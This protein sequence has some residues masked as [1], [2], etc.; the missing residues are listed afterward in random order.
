MTTVNRFFNELVS[1]RSGRLLFR[2]FIK[3]DCLDRVS[4]IIGLPSS[5]ISQQFDLIV[6]RL[7]EEPTAASSLIIVPYYSTNVDSS[8]LLSIVLLEK[9]DLLQNF[10]MIA[11]WDELISKGAESIL[12][13]D[14]NSAEQLLSL[15]EQLCLSSISWSKDSFD[16]LINSPFY[17]PYGL[18]PYFVFEEI[19]S[20][21]LCI[22]T[23]DIEID[24]TPF[25]ASNPLWDEELHMK[26]IL[27]S[28]LDFYRS[29]K[30][31]YQI[32]TLNVEKD[33][34]DYLD[35]PEAKDLLI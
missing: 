29:A 35:S 1:K 19:I 2:E 18:N 17:V 24:E 20:T 25:Y 26:T 27:I 34:F 4:R 6:K 10:K 16:E 32:L 23:L 14:C 28:Y 30:T 33:F 22:E 21:L 12:A 3:A 7:T 31:V 8:Q 15:K 13:L 11:E 5:D 9:I